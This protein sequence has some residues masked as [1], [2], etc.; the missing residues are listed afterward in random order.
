MP[1]EK[2]EQALLIRPGVDLVTD[3]MWWQ[4][5]VCQSLADWT[6]NLER[7]NQTAENYIIFHQRGMRHS[8]RRPCFHVVASGGF[9]DSIS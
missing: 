8:S 3:A 2:F 4:N 7:G 6:V 1:D 5:Y 9:C